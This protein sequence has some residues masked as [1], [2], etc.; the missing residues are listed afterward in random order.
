M[1]GLLHE[2]LRKPLS[3]GSEDEGDLAGEVELVQRRAAVCDERH[4]CAGSVVERE[5]GNPEDRA[6]R[7]PQGFRTERIGAA[8]GKRDRRTEGVCCAQ[9]RPDVAG[10]GDAPQSQ[11]RLTRLARQGR[12]TEDADDASRMGQ[13]RDGGEELGLDALARDEKLDR[14]D[15]GCRSGVDQV[16][17]LDGKEPELLAL[18]F[19]REELPDELQRRVR[20]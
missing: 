15:P 13:R 12:G 1:I 7:R 16:L 6:R 11:R 18:A 17:A 2:L 19:L 14:L 3:L 10:I 5:Q 4:P 9:Q 20:R 8:L